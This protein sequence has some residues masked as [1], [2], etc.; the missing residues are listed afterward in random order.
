VQTLVGVQP[1][2]PHQPQCAGVSTNQDVLAV[3]QGQ[4][5]VHDPPCAA[6]KLG[7]G[8]QQAHLKAELGG[9]HRCGQTRPTSADHR[10]RFQK[11]PN[12]CIFQASHSLRAGVRVTRWV[13]TGKCAVSISCNTGL[14]SGK[15]IEDFVSDSWL[16][17]HFDFYYFS[18]QHTYS[19]P[20]PLVMQ[21][22]LDHRHCFANKSSEILHVGDNLQTD[23]KLC[24]IT[25]MEFVY[26][27][28]ARL[29]YNE[30][31]DNPGFTDSNV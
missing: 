30:I 27:D 21:Y 29:N 16:Q 26:F 18:D 5:P 25:G 22:M 12:A 7:S 8:F 31:F 14:I 20:N 11:R 19:K 13:S 1:H 24:E 4:T 17:Y 10:D 15:M 9:A 2:G 28:K 23:G 6:T 3:V